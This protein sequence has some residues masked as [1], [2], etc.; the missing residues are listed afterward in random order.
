MA[1]YSLCSLILC[2]VE[3]RG[4]SP[5]FLVSLYFN[6]VRLSQFS[7]FSFGSLGLKYLNIPLGLCKFSDAEDRAGGGGLSVG[8]TAPVN[9]AFPVGSIDRSINQIPS[10]VLVV[11]FFCHS[12]V[13]W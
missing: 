13:S 9:G 12:S 5:I 3:I 7:L 2:G 1:S 8:V 11:K 10:N 4:T 6:Y